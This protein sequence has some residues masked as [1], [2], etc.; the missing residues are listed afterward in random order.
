MST[1]HISTKGQVIIPKAIREAYQL[2]AGQELEVEI[3]Q[4]GILLRI[5]NHTPKTTLNNLLGCTGYQGKTKT[6]EEI[7][8]DIQQGIIKEWGKHDRD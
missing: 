3:V 2:S 4:Q 5:K 7:E 1:T 8:V 6:L